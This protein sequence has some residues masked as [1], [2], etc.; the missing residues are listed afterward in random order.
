VVTDW[1]DFGLLGKQSSPKGGDSLPR[2]PLN[3]YAKFDAAS[4]ILAREIRN[5]TKLQ[6]NEQRVNDISTPCLSACVDKKEV[7]KKIRKQTIKLS[8]YATVLLYRS[9]CVSRHPQLR[10]VEPTSCNRMRATLLGWRH[11]VNAFGVKA[12]W[13]IPFVD[14]RVGGR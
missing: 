2:T 10:S 11:L 13:F 5:G 1:S 3:H 9:V 7:N 4:F 6:T 8:H 12:G 14:K